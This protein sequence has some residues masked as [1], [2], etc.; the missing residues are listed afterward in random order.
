MPQPVD[1]KV[2]KAELEEVWKLNQ[3]IDKLIKQRTGILN[4]LAGR[5]GYL[6][7][8]H[9]YSLLEMKKGEEKN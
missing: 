4:V 1:S 5:Y 6:V 9:H 2:I 8:K 3:R 7:V